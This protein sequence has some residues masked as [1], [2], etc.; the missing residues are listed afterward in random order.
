MP[1]RVRTAA[2]VATAALALPGCGGGDD[3]GGGGSENAETK[4]AVTKTASDAR[5]LRAAVNT[6]KR[7]TA[8]LIAAVRAG[9]G[10]GYDDTL[11]NRVYELRV[12][13][14]E[15]DQALR[16]IAFDPAVEDRVNEILGNDVVSIGRLDPIIEAKRWPNDTEER[17]LKVLGDIEDTKAKVDALV[18][19]L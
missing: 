5:V 3:G 16:R 11:N 2:L 4:P 7:D 8:S 9:L 14:Y 15:F 6:Y 12:A 18:A 1:A 17:V 10:R 19:R 13:I